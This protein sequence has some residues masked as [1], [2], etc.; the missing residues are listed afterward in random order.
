MKNKD[1]NKKKKKAY[2]KL[3]WFRKIA[4]TSCHLTMSSASRILMEETAGYHRHCMSM[5]CLVAI[6]TSWHA[7]NGAGGKKLKWQLPI[8]PRRLSS[9]R[10]ERRG[11]ARDVSGQHSDDLQNQPTILFLLA[12]NMFLQLVYW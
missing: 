4:F 1:W 12:D 2:D 7:T 10:L 8:L 11:R 6:S 5:S 3:L 9:L